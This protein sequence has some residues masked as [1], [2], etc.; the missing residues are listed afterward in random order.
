[1]KPHIRCRFGIWYC[2]VLKGGFV[3]PPYGHGYRPD[4]ALREWLRIFAPREA[5]A[6]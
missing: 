4:D 6:A 1:M 5:A 3:L 2:G